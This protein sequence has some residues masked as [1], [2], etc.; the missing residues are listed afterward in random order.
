MICHAFDSLGHDIHRDRS[1]EARFPHHFA[2]K[3]RF[4]LVA[5]HQCHT[6]LS[7]LGQQDPHNQP[8]KSRPRAE[9]DPV[10]GRRGVPPLGP[11]GGGGA[12]G[13]VRCRPG[14][15]LLSVPCDPLPP[16]GEGQGGGNPG[17][18]ARVASTA[19]ATP[20]TCAL[21]AKCR[22]QMSS[23]VLGAT[24]LIVFCHVFSSRAYV[25]S[26]ANVSR[27]TPKT[28]AKSAE[29]PIRF[30]RIGC[31]S[32][33]PLS[34]SAGHSTIPA[35]PAPRWSQTASLAP[36]HLDRQQIRPGLAIGEH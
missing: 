3:C 7:P 22:C 21:S 30:V 18:A 16:C 10:N 27:E 1:L 26:R 17:P 6:G 2:Q 11:E 28:R 4:A 20:N 35:E 13:R 14:L 34:C 29:S 5:V 19:S 24:R 32:C 33:E 25:S 23:S 9:I 8:R 36:S 12:S 15:R 31:M